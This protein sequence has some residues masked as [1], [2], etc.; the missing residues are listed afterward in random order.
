MQVFSLA[1]PS[2]AKRLRSKAKP[3]QAKFVCLCEAV[4]HSAWHTTFAAPLCSANPELSPSPL[5]H[6]VSQVSFPYCPAVPNQ[7]TQP[8]AGGCRVGGHT[9]SPAAKPSSPWGSPAAGV[10]AARIWPRGGHSTASVA[11]RTAAGAGK[12]QGRQG[13]RQWVERARG[14]PATPPAPPFQ[15]PASQPGGGVGGA[16]AALAVA[17]ATHL[18][19]TCVFKPSPCMVFLSVSVSVPVSASSQCDQGMQQQKF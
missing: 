3:C 4:S 6:P 11:A 15:V 10:E 12:R 19:S 16:A 13:C 8:A 14:S 1:K 7:G 18:H 9:P 17:P 2:L 5:P